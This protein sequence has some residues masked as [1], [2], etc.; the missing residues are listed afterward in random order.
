LFYFF[1]YISLKLS[2]LTATHFASFEKLHNTVIECLLLWHTN[3]EGILV[4][5][6]VNVD[7]ID[8]ERSK[9]LMHAIA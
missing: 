2:A 6:H 5:L 7:D 4:T 9:T 1:V 8:R 3:K